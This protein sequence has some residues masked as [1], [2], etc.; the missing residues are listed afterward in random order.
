MSA[1]DLTRLLIPKKVYR[2]P[3]DRSVLTIKAQA[4]MTGFSRL[5]AIFGTTALAGLFSLCGGFSALAPAAEL[6]ATQADAACCNVLELRQYTLRP[7]TREPFV[8]LFDTVFS[9][10]LDA[11]GMTVI[12]QFRDL[13]RPDRFVWIRGFQDMPARA[14]E[15]AAFYQ[16]DLWHARRAE[17]NASIDDSDNVLL[18]EPASP[19]LRFSNIPPRPA[20]ADTSVRAGL[21]VVTLYYTKTDNPRAF[22][23]L[24]DRSLR[25]RAE[26]DGARTVAAYIASKQENNYPKLAVRVGEHIFVWFAMF[27]NA[28]AYASYQAKLTADKTWAANWSLAREKLTRDPEVLRLTPTPRSRLR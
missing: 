17:A 5:Q 21:V 26:A 11:T 1:H 10:P 12:G 15:L 28:D 18:L 23:T 22:G 14:T 2:K 24:F 13:D 7:G 9:D 16:G 20:A 3:E 27:A 8:E 6:P 25:H 19:A 4:P